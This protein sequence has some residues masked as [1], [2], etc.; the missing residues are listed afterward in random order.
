MGG[1]E[2]QEIGGEEWE[3]EEKGEGDGETNMKDLPSLGQHADPAPKVWAL[4]SGSGT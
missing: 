3:Q 2:E 1:G 4:P